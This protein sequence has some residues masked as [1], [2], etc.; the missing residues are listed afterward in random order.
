MG[1][2]EYLVASFWTIL[3][4]YG[5]VG[6]LIRYYFRVKFSYYSELMKPLKA[7]KSG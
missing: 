4:I 3:L 1:I 2:V 7:D 6:A 5:C